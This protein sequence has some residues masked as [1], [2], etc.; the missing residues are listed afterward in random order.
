M[1]HRDTFQ[2][3]FNNYSDIN[4][5]GHESFCL[6]RCVHN[7]VYNLYIVQVV[8]MV[9]YTSITLKQCFTVPY[10]QSIEPKHTALRGA[11]S[12]NTSSLILK[13]KSPCNYIIMKAFIEQVIFE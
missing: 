13:F 2:T 6:Y 8:N 11:T 7:C 4:Q 10:L 5:T 3:Y 9:V 1:N 12:T